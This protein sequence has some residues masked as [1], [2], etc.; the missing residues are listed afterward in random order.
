M[1]WLSL[2]RHHG[3]TSEDDRASAQDRRPARGHSYQEPG[4]EAAAPQKQKVVQDLNAASEGARQ[5]QLT[6]ATPFD[7]NG[8]EIRV[9]VQDGQTWFVS[10]DVCALLKH[11]NSRMAIAR[12]DDDE[13]GVTSANTLG[14]EQT[15]SMV[16]ESGLYHLIFRSRK[17]QAKIF[18]RWVTSEVLPSIRKTGSYKA[19]AADGPEEIRPLQVDLPS[20][21]RYVIMAVPGQAA[22]VRRPE[23]DAMF[24]KSDALDRQLLGSVRARG[25]NWS[26]V[27]V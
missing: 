1:L 9:A 20:P 25:G 10:A 26:P 16:N 8:Q 12:L 4:A 18:R 23:Y 19:V 27:R 21:G 22:H 15:L 14:G 11:S 24:A 17:P 7:F 6:A 3:D 5:L 2:E 13:K